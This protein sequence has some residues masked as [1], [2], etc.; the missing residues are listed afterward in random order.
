MAP[1]C[2]WKI[3]GMPQNYKETDHDNYVCWF[4][5]IKN[6]IR[7]I[8]QSQSNKVDKIERINSVQSVEGSRPQT[9]SIVR[10]KSVYKPSTSS[11]NTE[12][13]PV[14]KLTKDDIIS[15]I[16]NIRS[17]IFDLN[18]TLQNLRLIIN[19]VRFLS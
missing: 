8:R 4:V 9:F 3:K 10:S 14:K 5:A 6:T 12:V 2:E 15:H 19:K 16:E 11:N 18:G 1:S 13:K 7:N 17:Q